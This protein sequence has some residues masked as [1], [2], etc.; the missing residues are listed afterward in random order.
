MRKIKKSLFFLPVFALFGLPPHDSTT[1]Q[2]TAV[3]TTTIRAS[4][5]D[6]KTE[7]VIFKR[8]DKT[9]LVYRD[10]SGYTDSYEYLKTPAFF[11]IK[12][13]TGMQAA[14]KTFDPDFKIWN[15]TDY[16]RQAW[17][18]EGFAFST[19]P[20]TSLSVG[21]GDFNGD[22]KEDAM[23][24]G[25]NNKYEML[26][27]FLSSETA[28]GVSYKVLPVCVG[29]YDSEF[30]K[31]Y[32]RK[33]SNYCSSLASTKSASKPTAFIYKIFKKGVYFKEGYNYEKYPAFQLK[34]DAFSIMSIRYDKD[35]AFIAGF[36]EFFRWDFRL[37]EIW[38]TSS[39]KRQKDYYKDL[40]DYFYRYGLH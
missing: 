17:A 7:E 28:S 19:S 26:L 38:E 11:N 14:L 10:G 30:Y 3:D 31:K 15:S 18:E 33:F 13:S 6:G 12:I 8:G 34:T 5:G 23:V 25:H 4:A 1:G 24:I 21:L 22:K 40:P 29:Y 27:A 16:P 9:I 32:G 39:W 37:D 35:K 36:D 20:K 2:G